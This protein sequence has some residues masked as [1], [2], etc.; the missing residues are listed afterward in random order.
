MVTDY[1]KLALLTAP[2]VLKLL[3]EQLP[4]S[5]SVYCADECEFVGDATREFFCL[6]IVRD[7]DLGAIDEML[8]PVDI[9]PSEQ[10]ELPK[11]SRYSGYSISVKRTDDTFRSGG[12]PRSVPDVLRKLA[13][14]LG[15]KVFFGAPK[16]SNRVEDICLAGIDP[17]KWPPRVALFLFVLAFVHR[18]RF[19][20]LR[21]QPMQ[22]FIFYNNHSVHLD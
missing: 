6:N 17:V 13:S 15:C 3:R 5:W 12:L 16:P 19:K 8:Y 18:L 10:F 20:P 9:G 21:D 7:Y 14:L 11:N 22:P 1:R 2:Q 4:K